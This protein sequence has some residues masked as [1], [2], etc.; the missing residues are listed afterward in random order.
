MPRSLV[1]SALLAS[2]L[3]SV[4]SINTAPAC[5]FCEAPD[6]TL[7]QQVQQSDVAVLAQWAEGQPADR[8]KG[9][10][11]STTYEVVD[12]V[13][14]ASGTLQKGTR[15]EIVRYRP[16]KKGDLFLMLGSYTTV[17]EWGSPIEVSET[18]Y[19]YITQAPTR[20][21]SARDRLSYFVRFLEFSD[22]V[23][24]DDA[25]AEFASSPYED[26]ITIVDKM[27]REK[28]REWITNKETPVN[29]LG[30]YG[31]MLGLCG[32]DSDAE[33]M[34]A[35]ILE[36]SS[37]FRIGIDGIMA[38]YVL[39][40]GERGLD[41]LDRTKLADKEQDFSEH[42]A[43]AQMVRFLWTYGKGH[44]PPER[45]KQSMRLLV[46]N[47]KI[48]DLVIPDLARWQDWELTPRLI[49]LFGKP[50]YDVPFVQRKII[51]FM[52]SAIDAVP[53]EATTRPEYAR[54]A[55]EFLTKVEADD[56]DLVRMAKKTYFR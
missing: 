18:S 29:R 30:L 15:F 54:Q 33:L 46:E 37:G 28:L 53:K 51:H 2:A 6:V 9:F 55:E 16:G 31:L 22:R 40:R 10:A 5:P 23:I 36:P 14:D 43:C 26:V 19:N 3:L 45:L 44:I 52:W 35:K 42:V 49:E 20:E 21:A 34:E 38:G 50:G 47:P 12:V 25:Y 24:G 4:V 32:N 17:V 41:L 13:H 39:L 11:G 56:P 27:P 48:A 8:E 1:L 7:S